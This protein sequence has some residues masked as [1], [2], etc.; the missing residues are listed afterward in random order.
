M[1]GNVFDDQ[2]LAIADDQVKRANAAVAE[3]MK[4][5][6]VDAQDTQGPGGGAPGG[7]PGG[8]PGGMP[9]GD[10]AAGG[11]PTDPMAAMG[12]AGADPAAMGG[13]GMSEDR[14]RQLIQESMAMQGGAGGAGGGAGALGPNG[15]P[16]MKVDVN[17]EIYHV[18][19]LLVAMM[20]YF[21]IPVSPD[22][23]LGDPAEDPYAAPGE[24]ASDP[25]SAGASPGA[26]AIPPIKPMGGASPALAAG[27]GGG[28]G[29]AS[30]GGGGQKMGQYYDNGGPIAEQ[31]V[32]M[33]SRSSA[34]A[35]LVRQANSR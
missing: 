4:G 25:A 18:K 20:N 15:K 32:T 6:F 21:Q 1:R 5:A 17:T 2:L 33:S 3:L 34:I 9:G 27:G 30:M 28:G 23:L 19:R 14:V 29:D 26:S 10:P 11:M 8:M 12:P 35:E 31:L 24:A 16:K 13:G 7:D 22:I